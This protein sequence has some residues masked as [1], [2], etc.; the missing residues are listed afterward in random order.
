[1]AVIDASKRDVQLFNTSAGSEGRELSSLSQNNIAQRFR[2]YGA[3]G[4]AMAPS[5]RQPNDAAQVVR[6]NFQCP[7]PERVTEEL[8][9]AGYS[10]TQTLQWLPRQYYLIFRKRDS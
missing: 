5:S 9:A 1:V 10:L 6:P 2:C 7:R 8:N 3:R 4:E